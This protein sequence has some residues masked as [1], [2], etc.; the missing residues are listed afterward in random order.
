MLVE[1]W[2]SGPL[3]VIPSSAF[4]L[5][6]HSGHRASLPGYQI[7]LFITSLKIMVDR[8]CA[9]RLQEEV[10]P[11]TFAGKSEDQSCRSADLRRGAGYV[12]L[13]QFAIW[14]VQF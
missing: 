12:G 13:D 1:D 3:S 10:A 6:R 7:P 4:N 5:K 2:A 8:S 9:P 14:G 11:E